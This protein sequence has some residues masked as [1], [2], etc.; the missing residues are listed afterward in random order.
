MA[1]VYLE[2]INAFL[3]SGTLDTLTIDSTE[4]NTINEALL[5]FCD[6]S[7]NQLVGVNWD[8]YRSKLSSFNKAMQTRMKLAKNLGD[9]IREALQLLKDYMGEDLMLDS[10]RLDEYRYQRQV[11]Q[12]SIDTLNS[13]L[14]E[15]TQIEY[16]DSSGVTRVQ[17][18]PLYDASEVREQISLA[19]ETLTEL[20]RII[21][22][23]EGLDA[24]YH[25]AEAIL[26][27]AFSEISSFQSE[28]ESILPDATFTYKR[29]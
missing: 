8:N 18:V 11:C 23:I 5:D 6:L 25:Q 22:K 17:T 3:G 24:V 13:M 29:A 20:D 14:S 16:R 19:E 28:V 21:D 27:A 26:Q 10:S 15:T 12:K 4:G 7:S 9:A 1:K 2:E